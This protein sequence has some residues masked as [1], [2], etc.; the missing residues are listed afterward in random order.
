MAITTE[1]QQDLSL[2]F[3]FHRSTPEISL[4]QHERHL[5]IALGESLNG[6]K[7]V[8]LDTKYWIILRE[9][10]T[11]AD[12]DPANA[13]LLD[14]LR[15]KVALGT[16]LC[17]ISASTFVE[18]MK[19]TDT[20]SRLATATLIDELSHGVCLIEE[21]RR[22]STEISYFLHAKG[23]TEPLHP[24]GDLVWCKVSYVLGFLHPANTALDAATELI[25]QKSFLDYMW[26]V[27]LTEMMKRL[28]SAQ[29]SALARSEPTTEILNRE[30][31][32][33]SDSLRSF[34]QTYGAEVRGLVAFFGEA[35]LGVVETMARKR[36]I[37]VGY[38]SQSDRLET[39]NWYKN[40][41]ASALERDQ[42]S[43]GV[44]EILRTIHIHACLHAAVRWNKRR[45]LKDNDLADFYHAAA[46]LAYHDAFFTERSL[47]T[48]IT[49]NHLALDKLYDCRTIVTVDEA[50]ECLSDPA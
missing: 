38:D 6:K 5:C 47:R 15:R 36:Q 3:D 50:V 25:I 49:Q 34:S 21:E 20:T 33:H 19:Q 30:N 41:L 13:T 9:A 2:N 4:D 35:I 32:L 42:G 12:G 26:V 46:A 14:M 48:L 8:Y 28:D 24:L 23:T 1:M 29:F 22:V 7:L 16:L 37:P 31:L 10:A 27:P 43:T 44:R 40:L 11:N 45:K 18:L 17:P 39:M